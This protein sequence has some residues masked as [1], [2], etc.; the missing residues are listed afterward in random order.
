MTDELHYIDNQVLF[1]ELMRRAHLHPEMFFDDQL[2]QIE[3]LM[4]VVVREC[5]E[6]CDINDQEQGDIL[7]DHF[8][9][10]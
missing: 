3:R 7:R 10:R 9:V 5:A 4:R 2:D 6:L 1:K 8:G